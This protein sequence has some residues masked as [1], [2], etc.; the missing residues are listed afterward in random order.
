MIELRNLT[1]RYPAT[2][3]PALKDLSLS[4]EEGEFVSIVGANGAGK[5]TLCYALA[6]FIPHFYRGEL[7]GGLQVAGHDLQ[8]AN[9]EQLAGEVGLVFQDPFNQISGARFTV[10]EEIAFGLENLG[11][12]RDQMPGRIASILELTGLEGLAERS[13]YKLSGGQQQRLALASVMVMAPRLLVLDEPTS[14]LDPAGT[15]EVFEALRTW[16]EA[17]ETTVVLAEHKLEWVA[18]F[19]DRVLVLADGRLLADG[20]PGSTLTSQAARQAAVGETRYTAAARLARDRGAATA[21]GPLPVSL[22]QAVEF[23]R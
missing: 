6:G 4:I 3:C 16:T 12:P 11:V 10:R 2:E 5:S 14:Q 8:S 22:R 13:P 20:P 9:P 1:Y 21:D 15:R 18:G 23:F 7:T 19:S 17:G